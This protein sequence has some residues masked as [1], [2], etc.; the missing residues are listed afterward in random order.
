M[1][2]KLSIATLENQHR[3][4]FIRA[5]TNVLSSQIAEVTYAQI[6]DGLPL[7][8]TAFD[9]YRSC[10]CVGHPLLDEHQELCPGVI[11]H[12]RELGA[13]FDAGALEMDSRL[14]HD[15]QSASPGSRGFNTR[16]IELVARAVHEIAVW[17]YKQD[18]NRHKD[19]AFGLW[20]PPQDEVRFFPHTFPSTLLCH[21]WYRDHDQYPEGIADCVGYWAE[22]RIFG[23]VVLFDRRDP[24]T[25]DAVYLHPDRRDVIYRIYRLLD[26]QK[27]KLL[28]F[29]L[30]DTTP[31]ECPLPL[32]PSDNN[33]HRVDPEEAI[34][35]TGIYR[36]RWERRLRPLKSGDAR[37]KDVIDTWNYLSFEDWRDATRRG[38]RARR[39]RKAKERGL[40]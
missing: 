37:I 22:A 2:G 15:Y 30:C 7:S 40:G 31:A 36:D 39:E 10:V 34:E 8:D 16:L 14:V 28:Q 26:D 3:D 1:E 12:A 29:M 5:V 27:H 4:I 13:N 21:A 32:L 25:P 19:D 35:T 20:R 33:R 6:V 38:R 23:G 9:V 11:E 17:L 18:T 24:E